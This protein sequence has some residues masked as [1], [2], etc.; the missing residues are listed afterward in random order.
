LF[1]LPTT[2]YDIG[3]L[4]KVLIFSIGKYSQDILILGKE[5]KISYCLIGAWIIS[6]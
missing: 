1:G 4:G 6:E 2:E 5:L 3:I